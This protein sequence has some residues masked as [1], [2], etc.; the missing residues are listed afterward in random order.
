MNVELNLSGFSSKF[1]LEVY[2]KEAVLFSNNESDTRPWCPC[3]LSRSN[4][5]DVVFVAKAHGVERLLWELTRDDAASRGI[6][7]VSVMER[8]GI[9]WGVWKPN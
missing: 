7:M 2:E 4:M 8:A 3:C 9:E 1:H 5:L 6:Q